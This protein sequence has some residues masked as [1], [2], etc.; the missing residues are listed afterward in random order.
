MG[1]TATVLREEHIEFK[2]PNQLKEIWRRLK[3]DKLAMFG[4]IVILLIIVMAV[5]A[6]FAA[7]Y[8]A[9]IKLNTKIRLQPPSTEHLFGT[10]SYGR[11][12]FAR[13][14]Y[15]AR[16][17]LAIGFF[18]AVLATVC[19]SLIGAM[20]GYIGGR[21]DSIIMRFLDIVSAIPSTLLALAVVAAMGSGVMKLC[22]AL[23][24][25][26]IPGFVRIVRSAVLGIADQEYIEACR[27]GGTSTWR[28]L[29]R[30]ILPNAI[31]P[32]IVQGTM[33]VSTMIRT[34]ATLSF[35]GL[36]IN[37]PTPEWGALI[38][39]AKEFLRTCPSMMLFPAGM[40]CLTAF[41]ISVFGDGL[42]D[43]LDPRLK[44]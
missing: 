32:V 42:R 3:K 18:S 43:A 44:S 20:T 8:E 23:S 34:I 19:G 25:T 38:S 17:S 39:E 29:T 37:P 10:D 2:K 5:C 1:E 12:I 16:M 33:E 22:L 41:S 30:H 27:A 7:D 13:C 15:G 31:G 9:V 35:L 36:G 28:I 26:A 6:N 4:L 11:D 40:L 14:L 24:F 21:L